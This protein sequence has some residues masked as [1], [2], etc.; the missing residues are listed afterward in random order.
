MPTIVPRDEREQAVD[1]AADHVAYLVL[2]YGVLLVVAYR[3]LVDGQGSFELL[4]LVVGSGFVGAAIRARQGVVTPRT[5]GVWIATALVALV[6][7][8]ILAVAA[9]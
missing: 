8:L 4:A 3:G 7:A 5:A 1:R 9:R 2:A 6:V